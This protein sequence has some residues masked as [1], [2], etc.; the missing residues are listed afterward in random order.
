[1]SVFK[2]KKLALPRDLFQFLVRVMKQHRERGVVITVHA[3]VPAPENILKFL[4]KPDD[5][6]PG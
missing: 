1:M 3:V 2:G 6:L 5:A 4:E